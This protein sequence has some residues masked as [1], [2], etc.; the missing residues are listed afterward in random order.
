MQ[1]VFPLVSIITP[2]YNA[3]K[4]LKTCID[5]VLKQTYTNWELILVNDGSTDGSLDIIKQ[6][7]QLD[8]RIKYIDKINEGPSLSRKSGT[9]QAK[10]KYIQYLDSDDFLQENAIEYLTD[11]AEATNA[12][13]VA[14]PFFFYYSEN[15]MDISGHF[16][17]QEMTGMEYFN[18]IL[19][20][21]AY[22]S[23]WSN[24]LSRSLFERNDISFVPE[25]SFGEDAILMVQLLYHTQ[26]VVALEQ[27]ILYYRQIESS[28]CHDITPKRHEDLRT[29]TKWIERFMIEKG[30]YE[31]Y[32]NNL[33]LKN[34]EMAFLCMHWGYYENAD[35]DMK[36]IV[37]DIKKRP[38]LLKCLPGRQRKIINRDGSDTCRHFGEQESSSL[39]TPPVKEETIHSFC[40]ISRTS[41]PKYA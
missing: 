27:P 36:R 15:K 25:I 13:V 37:K 12:E 40:E 9:E 7:A 34:I 17:F 8:V 5:S 19:S 2:V 14:A 18:E 41:F 38:Q 21:R 33:I 31:S 32:R 39:Q 6:Y 35:K 16:S 28:I 30:L 22:W 29:Y 24:F 4:Y 3:E 20:G 23:V 10:G 1:P 11:K 26:K